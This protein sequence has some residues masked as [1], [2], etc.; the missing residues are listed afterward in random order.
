MEWYHGSPLPLTV[1]RAGSTFTQDR[2]LARVFSHK[3]AIVNREEDG[4]VLHTGTLPGFL[5]RI[6]EPVLPDDLLPHP[7]STLPDGLEWLTLRNFT[8]ECIE[9][10]MPLPSERLTETMLADFR[11][12]AADATS[13]PGTTPA[14]DSP[15]NNPRNPVLVYGTRNPAKLVSM[16]ETLRGIPVGLLDLSGPRAFVRETPEDG[17]TP[18]ENAMEKALGY[19][20]QLRVPVFSIDSGLYFTGVEDKDQ[21]GVH[22]R[23]MNG[24]RMDDA[25]MVR[26]YSALARKYGGFLEARYRN[27]F[28]LVLD[29]TH[30]IRYEGPDIDSEAFHL[31]DRPH[32]KHQEGFPLD[33]ISVEIRSGRHY[34]DLPLS[35]GLDATEENNGTTRDRADRTDLGV[36]DG[37]RGLFSRIMPLLHQF[38]GDGADA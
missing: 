14:F 8:L 26:H 12:M 35:S 20:R 18:I 2:T 11:A 22:I 16:R 9:A 32:A 38:A 6:A 4:N 33:S 34:F 23:R 36:I 37:F 27:A 31:V 15:R 19:W 28:C 7:T 5:Y 30:C 25:E 29:D 24:H 3:P 21:P 1:L 10:T 13:V 17:H